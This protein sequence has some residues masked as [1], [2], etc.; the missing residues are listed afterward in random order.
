MDKYLDQRDFEL[1]QVDTDSMYMAISGISINE[2]V[3]SELQEQYHNGGKVELLS[4]LK[5]HDRTSWLFQGRVS[6][7]EDDRSNEQMLLLHQR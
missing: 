4:T 5:Y 1:I 7:N 2:I 3:R 6:G